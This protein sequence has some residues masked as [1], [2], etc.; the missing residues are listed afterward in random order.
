MEIFEEINLFNPNN[1]KLRNCFFFFFAFAICGYLSIIVSFCPYCDDWCRYTANI[2]VGKL[3]ACRYFTL[4]LESL[5]YAS[6]FVS[7][8]APLSHLFSCAL[9]AY[10]AVICLKLFNVNI[11][12]KWKILCLTPMIVNPYLLELMMYR[13]DNFFTIIGLLLA[14]LA[15]YLSSKNDKKFF[16]IQSALL[17]ITIFIYQ[18]TVSAYLII[19]TYLFT[20]QIQSGL[21]FFKAIYKMRYWFYSMLTVAI[22]YI[23]FTYQ[24]AYSTTSDGKVLV[25]PYNLENIKIISSNI[26]RYFLTLYEDWS[27]NPIGQIFFGLAFIFI[28][29]TVRR[30]WQKNKS[31]ISLFIVLLGIFCFFISPYGPCPFLKVLVFKGNESIVPRIMCSAGIVISLILYS[32]Y[33][34]FEQIKLSK[35]FYRFLVIIFS[36]WSLTFTNSAGNTIHCLRLLQHNVIYDLSK[37]V[38]RITNNNEKISHICV[39]GA[40]TSQTLK[41]FAEFYP[42]ILRIVPEQWCVPTYC[43]IALMNSDFAKQLLELNPKETLFHNDKYKNKKL[44]KTH[45][46]YDIFVIDDSIMFIEFKDHNKFE[47]PRHSIIRVK[48]D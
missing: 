38:F 25:I 44:I 29:D 26:L 23:P 8:F 41:N 31:V 24:L 48:E 33:T 4:F 16:F 39:A 3:N 22:L 47:S 13:F 35:I 32:N 45:M 14:V 36:V 18:P 20:L 19:F 11:D 43:Q 46:K 15:A 1:R 10:G 5:V 21:S 6:P 2:S 37:D 17:F 42:I 9:L 34:L 28:L 27:P 30:T 12:D 40:V 7:D